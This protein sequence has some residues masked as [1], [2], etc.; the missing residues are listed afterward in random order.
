V[1]SESLLLGFGKEERALVNESMV[2]VWAKE[3]RL[4]TKSKCRR[5]S[6]KAVFILSS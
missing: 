1:L 5:N 6:F 4:T 3:K 2:K